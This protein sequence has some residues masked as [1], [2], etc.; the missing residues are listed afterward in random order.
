MPAVVYRVVPV[1]CAIAFT[2]F[3]G[4][5]GIP[6]LRHDWSSWIAHGGFYSHAW[7]SISG[8]R[9]D[10]F[11]SPRPYPTDYLLVVANV[12]LFSA[13]GAYGTF[14]ADAFLIGLT[15]A[16]GAMAL[17]RSFAASPLA[18][19]AG[20]FFA[21][22]NPWTYNQVVAGHI[23]MVLAY[24]A[25]MLLTSELLRNRPSPHATAAY[26]ILTM[27][28]LQFFVPS[29]V[30][31]AVWTLATRKTWV[32][33][34]AGTI[35]SLPV[36][37]G[38][39]A[40][41][42]YLHAIPYTLAWQSNAS[43][44]PWYAIGLGGYFAL[45]GDALPW[46][47]FAGTWGIVA[48]AALGTAA[49][50]VRSPRNAIWPV[51]A[52]FAVWAF[53][54]GDKG[55]AAAAYVWLVRHVA[56]TGLYRE[57]YDVVA[58]FCIAYLAACAYLSA[59]LRF[60]AHAWLLCSLALVAGWV[61]E[62]PARYWVPASKLPAVSIVAP[63]NWR[64][65]LMPPLQPIR[66]LWGSGL[67]PD[68]VELPGNITP[69]N[70]QQF[71]YPE[72][73]ALIRYAL[74]RDARGLEALSVVDVVERPQ[75]QTDVEKL[76]D[77]LAIVPAIPS[78][79][80]T[81]DVALHA[82]AEL[83]LDALPPLS[84]IPRP[85]WDDAIFF[86]DASGVDGPGVP[87]EWKDAPAVSTVAPSSSRVAAADGW[88]DAR[89]AFVAL[90]DLSQG[91]GGAVT[92][93]PYA[94]LAID[95]A[96]WTL[97]YVRGRLEAVDGHLVAT[98][99]NGYEW[100]PPQKSAIVRCRGL[101]VVVAQTAR[102]F[103]T[104]SSGNAGCRAMVPFALPASWLA[105]ATLPPSKDCLLRYNVRYDAHWGAW[106]AGTFLA[107]VPIDSTA[108]GWIVPA[109]DAEQR[110]VIV[111]GVAAIQF[112]LETLTV[113]LGLAILLTFGIRSLWFARASS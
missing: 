94:L 82:S 28:Q 104:R 103:E 69:L 22:C 60:A 109:H 108:N 62:P 55:I 21:V 111:E 39:V 43:V 86:G 107:H 35:A 81:G 2:L 29:L 38:L 12:A 99:T 7:S 98:N 31:V 58:L 113:V 10:G 78:P 34:V 57:L 6:T 56:A 18:A 8:W 68:A 102:P 89:S 37:V 100:L 9:T 87:P 70:T 61:M 85:L 101:C 59:R 96:R 46:Y 67:D 71:D 84:A 5:S 79:P 26:L 80:R 64:Y 49:A 83:T 50:L 66:F 91:L 48:L 4:F 14:L 19:T 88:V 3:L 16:A 15:V 90:P 97:A 44:D 51:L 32:P 36:W 20:A 73:P 42:S 106:T 53:A 63:P 52:F 40:E 41:S 17:T 105:I 112:A 13:L 92:S 25:M 93:N 65:A 11:G 23:Y 95:P 74:A 76:G 1:A 77:Q 54:G 27:G 33:L 110:V 75:F 45:Y 24:G 30:A 47:A 72:S